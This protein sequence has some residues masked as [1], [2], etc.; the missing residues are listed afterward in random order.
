MRITNKNRWLIKWKDRWFNFKIT[1]RHTM[2]YPIFDRFRWIVG[3][4][5]EHGNYF[6]RIQTIRHTVVAKSRKLRT[7]W[8]IS[9]G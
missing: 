5:P 8:T 7:G 9:D 4:A 3:V 6:L 2:W 1:V